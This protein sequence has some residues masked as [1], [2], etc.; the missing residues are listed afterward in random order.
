MPSLLYR[1][2]KNLNDEDTQGENDIR[3]E[4]HSD[5]VLG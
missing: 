5:F 1:F 3:G 4:L 2:K